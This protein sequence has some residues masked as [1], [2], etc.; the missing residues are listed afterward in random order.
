VRHRARLFTYLALVE[1]GDDA[2]PSLRDEPLA[3]SA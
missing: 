2:S 3:E 1:P